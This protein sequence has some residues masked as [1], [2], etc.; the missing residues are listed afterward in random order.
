MKKYTILVFLAL[1]ALSGCV[2]PPATPKKDPFE[3]EQRRKLALA[4]M[5]L[6]DKRE[7]AARE[8]LSRISKE[9]MIAGVT[10]EA[11]FRLALLSLEPGE[12]KIDTA[13]TAR[14]LELILNNYPSSPWRSH[15]AALNG[16]LDAYDMSRREIAE[17][18]K[19][20]RGLKNTNTSLGKENRELHEDIKRFKKLDLELER[21][22]RR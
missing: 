13:K 18:D 5:L 12:K 14:S 7:A 6:E 1:L 11:L 4:R 2:T 3:Q 19:S 10:D 21:K 8:I 20:I 22:R 17:M 9:R 15:A 16:L